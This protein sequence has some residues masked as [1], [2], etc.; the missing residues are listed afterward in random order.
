MVD[1]IEEPLF[2]GLCGIIKNWDTGKHSFCD[3]AA[4]M[5]AHKISKMTAHTNRGIEDEVNSLLLVKGSNNSR[6]TG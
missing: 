3:T 6:G 1:Q 5:R 2:S 4:I